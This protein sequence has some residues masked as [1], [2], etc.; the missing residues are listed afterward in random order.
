MRLLWERYWWN[1][2]IPNIVRFYAWSH[3]F[4]L[5]PR[6][7]HSVPQFKLPFK[8]THQWI[9]LIWTYKACTKW[10][11]RRPRAGKCVYGHHVARCKYVVMSKVN[12]QKSSHCLLFINWGGQ[13]LIITL[14]KSPSTLWATRQQDKAESQVS[15]LTDTNKKQMASECL[16]L[17]LRNYNCFFFSFHVFSYFT[18]QLIL[19]IIIFIAVEKGWARY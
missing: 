3:P 13:W 8:V 19:C 6:V 18:Y 10:K 7:R 4:A 15:W 5:H 12:T 16:S 17:D 11:K 1:K 2:W 14:M 9:V